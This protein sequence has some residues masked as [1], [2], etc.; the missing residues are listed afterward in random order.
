MANACSEL[1]WILCQLKDF[2]LCSLTPVPLLRDDKAALYTASNL[3]FHERT[4]HSEIDCHL[5]Q[6]RL[7]SG[8]LATQHVS[9]ILQLAD[10]LTKALSAPQPTF[11][12]SK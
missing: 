2:G 10:L 8:M 6:E 5:I 12:L 7:S 11:L 4:K 9:S 1:T 3:M